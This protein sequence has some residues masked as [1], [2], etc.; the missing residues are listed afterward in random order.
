MRRL[1]RES[2]A[3]IRSTSPA[4]E[5]NHFRLPDVT[6]ESGETIPRPSG[7]FL[8]C[9]ND[10]VGE[11]YFGPTAFES[12]ALDIRDVI[13]AHL[14]TATER[15]RENL[16]GAQ[17]RI[18][19][20]VSRGEEQREPVVDSPPLI[21]PPFALLD[22]M[23]EPYFATINPH[24]PIWT[25]SRFC[26]MTAALRQSSSCPPG[27][28]QHRQQQ[29]QA[30]IVCCNSLIVMALAADSGNTGKPT[31]AARQAR[32]ASSATPLSSGSLDLAS[33][34][35]DNAKRAVEHIEPLLSPRLR[36]VQA[37]LSLVW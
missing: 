15:P 34:F 31:Q 25:K 8:P 26:Q 33:G 11:R 30:S 1:L 29:D 28:Q 5:S 19:Q 22:A 18:D 35:L 17:Q 23:V 4:A 20:L 3:S 27:Q 24:F 2:S 6:S 32:R 13:T 37:L 10:D 14:S 12:L 21:T 9:H 16:L 36:N 7:R